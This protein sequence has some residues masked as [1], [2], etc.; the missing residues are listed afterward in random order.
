M[1]E[2]G[3]V[4]EHHRLSGHESQQTPAESEGRNPA[5]GKPHPAGNRDNENR[6]QQEAHVVQ[7]QIPEDLQLR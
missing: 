1:V 3:V 7:S 2:D 6:T 5:Q 4:G